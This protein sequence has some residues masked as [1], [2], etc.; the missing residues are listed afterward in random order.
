MGHEV[1]TQGDES[2]Y[3][4]LLLE[5]FTGKRPTSDVFQGTSNLDNYVKAALL[6]QVVEIVDLVLLHEKQEG[7]M[8]ANQRLTKASTT[9]HIKFEESLI[10]I[11]ENGI[12]CST[13]VHGER[14]DIADA[15]AEMCRIRNKI[16]A[17]H[18]IYVVLSM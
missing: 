5:M 9:I 2:S 18:K 14:L 13:N 6:E 10:S 1:W 4:I 16:R 12:D 17:D 11:L 8:S 15:M 3:G 7:D